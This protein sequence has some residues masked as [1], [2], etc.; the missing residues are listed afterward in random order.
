[1]IF[2]CIYVQKLWIRFQLG[3][4]DVVLLSTVIEKQ[5]N[6]NSMSYDFIVCLICR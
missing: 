3:L 4:L 5:K 1:M 6:Q 2:S